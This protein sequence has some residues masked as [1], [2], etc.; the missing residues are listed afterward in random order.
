VTPKATRK[1]LLDW[2]LVAL[3]DMGGRA[4]LLRVG[5]HIWIA[6][7]ADLRGSGD[8]F[9]SWQYDYRWAATRLRHQGDLANPRNE[10]PGY[11]E[12]TPKGRARADATRRSF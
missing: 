9:Y 3:L 10:I 11:W 8:L 5:E 1:D 7:E 12:L 2:V 6:H 4:H